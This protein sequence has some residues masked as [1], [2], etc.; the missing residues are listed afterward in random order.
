MLKKQKYEFVK[1]ENQYVSMLEREMSGHV[2][3]D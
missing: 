1:I 2:R 3:A